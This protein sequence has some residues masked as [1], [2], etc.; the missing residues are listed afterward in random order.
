MAYFLSFMVAFKVSSLLKINLYLQHV[1]AAIKSFS[2]TRQSPHV[3]KKTFWLLQ[4]T[5]TVDV[6][7]KC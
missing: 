5:Y 3:L 2:L 1:I 6:F 4:N 7:H